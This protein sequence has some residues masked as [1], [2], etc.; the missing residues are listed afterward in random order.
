[1]SPDST[2][3]GTDPVAEAGPGL[4]GDVP[5]ADPTLGGR[6]KRRVQDVLDSGDLADGEEVRRF[7]SEFADYCGAAHG[8]ATANGTAA[9]HA[10][11]HAA[12][13]GPGD[14]VVTTPLSFIATANAVRHCGAEPIFA[15][16]NPLTYNLEPAAVE[17]AIRDR[18]GDVDA[19]LAVHLYG[20]PADVA[21]LRAIADA[22]D[23]PLIEDAAQAHGATY[24]GDPV[25]SLGDV[26]CFSFYPTKNM[27]TGEGGMVL[28]DDETVARRAARFVNHGRSENGTHVDVGHNF[29]MTNLAAAIGR[30]QLDRLPEYLEARRGFAETLTET[31]ERTS[32]V[33]P[34]VPEDRAHAY[35]QYTV[36]TAD[37][38]TVRRVL[39][40]FGVDTGVYYPTPIHEHPPYADRSVSAPVAE[41]AADQVLSL[42]VHPSLSERDLDVLCTAL[43]YA[44]RYAL[45]GRD[46]SE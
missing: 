28:T 1:M 4:D 13:I 17:T 39:E 29:R 8:V 30:V 46:P 15:D 36:R 16:V 41:A 9:L 35:N 24:R 31:V 19:V 38:G 18:D 34:T 20:L 40:E 5:L 22:H 33:A 21:E 7:E 2:G 3:S 10:G 37:R 27:T 25:G 32:L 6:A 42:P 26:A 11:L 12:G 23:V 43:V 44:D 14:A 45:D